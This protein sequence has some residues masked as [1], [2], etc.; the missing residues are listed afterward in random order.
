MNMDQFSSLASFGT[1]FL[2]AC[3]KMLLGLAA[4]DFGCGQGGES[5]ASPQR[6]ATGESTQAA[7]KRSAEGPYNIFRQALKQI[8]S[9]KLNPISRI[10]RQFGQVRYTPPG[11]PALSL[12]TGDSCVRTRSVL[13]CCSPL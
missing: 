11:H 1:E 13:D 5:G 3:L 7:D 10:V 2:R 12:D 6:A 9:R 4:R 8:T